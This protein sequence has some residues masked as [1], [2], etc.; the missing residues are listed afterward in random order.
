MAHTSAG[1][2]NVEVINKFLDNIN[3]IDN[4]YPQTVDENVENILQDIANT[5]AL[6][7]DWKRYVMP[8]VAYKINQQLIRYNLVHGFSGPSYETFESKKTEIFDLLRSFD[9]APF[10][11]QRLVELVC[12]PDVSYS[13]THKFMNGVLKLLSVTS[14]VTPA[15]PGVAISDNTCS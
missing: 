10:T 5:G 15:S 11:I 2:T 4:V 7:W 14:Y 12:N 1:R 6:N 9:E 13:S 3:I 8:F